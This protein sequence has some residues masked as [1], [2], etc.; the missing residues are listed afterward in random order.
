MNALEGKTYCDPKNS[1]FNC[2]SQWGDKVT[3]KS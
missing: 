2:I 1:T 3:K